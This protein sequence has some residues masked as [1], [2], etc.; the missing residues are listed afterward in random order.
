MTADFNQ[1]A[2]MVMCWKCADDMLPA[3]MLDCQVSSKRRKF[4]ANASKRWT[5]RNP[6]LDCGGNE[7]LAP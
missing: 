5:F 4:R 6:M 7:E 2:N 3:L 1:L